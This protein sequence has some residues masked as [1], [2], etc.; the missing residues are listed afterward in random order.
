MNPKTKGRSGGAHQKIRV[1][2]VFQIP[3]DRGRVG[4]GQVVDCEPPNPPYLAV[5]GSAYSRHEEPALR[6]IIRDKIR[7]LAPSLDAKI[8]HGDGKVAGNITPDLS[9]IP[10]PP[11]RVALNESDNYYI[12]SYDRKT[13]RPADPME[14]ATVPFRSTI[15]PIRLERA[16]Q[17]IHGVGDWVSDYDR[18]EYE[19]VKQLAERIKV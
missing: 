8:W 2:D 11:S 18:I 14:V 7:F 19:A 6:D 5:F 16:L 13:S 17:A 3:I 10:F 1:G 9:K 12:V 4:Y 15:A